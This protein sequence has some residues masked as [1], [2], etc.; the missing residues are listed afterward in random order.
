M[1]MTETP[2]ATPT[3]APDTPGTA[4]VRTGWVLSG[5]VVLFLVFDLTIKLLERPEAV[6]G[7]VQLG[8]PAGTVR[9]MG[10][11]L[12]LGVVLYAVPR[13]SVFGAVFTTAYLGGAVCAQVRVEA[14]LLGFTLFPVYV[15][16]LLWLGLYLRSA[17]LRRLVRTGY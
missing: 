6:Q 7:T 5:L 13:T 3:T 15:A 16:V 2:A 12:L 10:A 1:T 4:A 8:F 11:L 9:L 14:P 17:A